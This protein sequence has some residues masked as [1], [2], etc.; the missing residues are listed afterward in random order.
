[1]SDTVGAIAAALHADAEAVRVI[2]LNVA[3][4]QTPAYRR[5]IPLARA[6]FADAVGV[7]GTSPLETAIDTRAGTLQSTGEPLHLAIEGKGFFV[8]ATAQ[9]EVLTRRGDFRLDADGRLVT[10]AGDPLLGINGVLVVGGQQPL[11]SADGTVRGGD[12]AIDRIRIVDVAS[13]ASLVP[14]DD[15][16][17]AVAPG[18]EVLDSAAPQVRQGFLETSNVQTVN[19]TVQLIDAVRRFEMA[20]RFMRGYDSLM[21]QAISTLGKI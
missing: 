16:A 15:G 14:R 9:G 7:V 6:S 5:E 1:M 19:E 10:H 18:A 17:Y 4:A 12:T 20:Q 3:N 13:A 21:E 11:V 8:V 2:S